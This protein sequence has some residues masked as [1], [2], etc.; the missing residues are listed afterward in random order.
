MVNSS[1]KIFKAGN[2]NVHIYEDRRT[3][4][5]QSA[6]NVGKLIS[7]LLKEQEEI[8]MIFAA[9][10]SQNEFLE[11]LSKNKSIDW[12][13]ITAFHMDEYI[14]LPSDSPELFSRYL[15]DHIFSKVKFKNVFLINP[16]T[17]DPQSECSRYS[18]LLNQKPIDIVCMGIGENGHIAF[19]DPPVAD[20][21]DQALVKIVELEE[22]CKAQQ[23]NDAGFKTVDEVPKTA[24]TL[25]VPALFS[26]KFLNIVVP[27]IR[28]AEAVR[29]TLYSEISTKCPATILRTHSNAVLYLD[30]DSASLLN[31]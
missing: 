4:G 30:K 10:P 2:L 31:N 21:D 29:D 1:T 25:T 13:K 24:F 22:K 12:S 27:G 20:F 14:N 17:D 6:E 18:E 9:A 26:G 16:K 8:R 7:E 11:E 3:L 15:N 19:N 28:K 5:S 23:V